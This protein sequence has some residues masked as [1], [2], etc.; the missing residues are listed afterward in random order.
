M[1]W[2]T[3]K[4]HTVFN[5]RGVLTG[6][7]SEAIATVA[8]AKAPS[9]LEVAKRSSRGSTQVQQDRWLPFSM[10]VV[11][12]ISLPALLNG[13]P[14]DLLFDSGAGPTLIDP[15]LA[16][17]LKLEKGETSFVSGLTGGAATHKVRIDSLAIGGLNLHD[18]EADVIDFRGPLS[19]TGERADIV[20]G[21]RLLLTTVL[22]IDF[23]QSRMRL[24][25]QATVEGMK[26]P[27][28]I[29]LRTGD[30]GRLYVQ[31]VLEGHDPVE[32]QYDLGSSSALYVSPSYAARELASASRLSS[33]TAT[34]GVEGMTIND[35]TTI[36]TLT[37]AGTT[38]IDVPTLIPRDWN[39]QGP[40]LLGLPVLSRFRNVIDLSRN[41]LW[42]LPV[43]HPESEPF[44]KDRSGI[45]AN[46]L[47]DRLAVV[48]VAPN[49]PAARAG[50]KAGDEIVTLDG[51]RV[52]AEL[53]ARRPRPGAEAAGTK[54]ALGLADGRTIQITLQDYF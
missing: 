20:I 8:G 35:L 19:A 32:A 10:P 53:F 47:P 14:V 9:S 45:G 48:F 34:V 6:I 15:G 22:D 17:R 28:S 24:I 27:P 18:V 46:R 29:G 23:V 1:L 52:G 43:G 21:R 12:H 39:Q 16:K 49:S 26:L 42:L 40:A 41:R 37:F 54:E 5:R 31:V 4:R 33:Q 25:D 36:R 11:G 38:F 13:S 44:L 2:N 30:G 7:S 3:T 51:E 50:L